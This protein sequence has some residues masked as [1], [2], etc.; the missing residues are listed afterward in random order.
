MYGPTAC[1]MAVKALTRLCRC[2]SS[3][4]PLLLGDVI[5]IEILCMLVLPVFVVL[6][7]SL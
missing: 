7:V 3:H 5:S 4:E 6:D 1:L 2:K